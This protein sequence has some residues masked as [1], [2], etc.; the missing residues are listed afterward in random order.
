MYYLLLVQY[1][2]PQS[3]TGTT[4]LTQGQVDNV[5]V[6]SSVECRTVWKYLLEKSKCWKLQEIPSPPIS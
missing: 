4:V 1:A 6:Y 3:L 2:V 5:L